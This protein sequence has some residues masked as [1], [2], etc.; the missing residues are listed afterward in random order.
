[1]IRF[2]IDLSMSIDDNVS[3][4]IERIQEVERDSGASCTS[5]DR[6][7]HTGDGKGVVFRI[8]FEK[9]E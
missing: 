8:H 7:A 3:T 1:M 5:L 4:L 9:R 2:G 6:P